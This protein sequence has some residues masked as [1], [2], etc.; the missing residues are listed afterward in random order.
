M[1]ILGTLKVN[2]ADIR[3]QTNNKA[4]KDLKPCAVDA[5]LILQVCFG[6]LLFIILSLSSRN[7]LRLFVRVQC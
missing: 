5:Y 1:F 7:L 3:P 2:P 4:P 6:N